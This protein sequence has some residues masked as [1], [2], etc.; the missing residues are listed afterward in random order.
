MLLDL[1]LPQ[2]IKQNRNNIWLKP[3]KQNT[4]G[5][6]MAQGPRLSQAGTAGN[7]KVVSNKR[8]PALPLLDAQ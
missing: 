4:I 8:K 7:W 6:S 5:C 3:E 1:N 2:L